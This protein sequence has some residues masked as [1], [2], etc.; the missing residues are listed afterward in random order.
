[1]KEKNRKQMAGLSYMRAIAC[2]GIVGIHTIFSALLL[3]PESLTVNEICGY[4]AMVHNLMWTVPC[5]LMVTGALLLDK[6]KKISY[7]KLFKKYILRILAAMFFWGIWY[8]LVDM[9]LDRSYN[10]RSF[11]SGMY[12]VFAGNSWSHMWYL[13]CLIGLYLFLPFYK[14]I[15]NSCRKRDLSYLLGVSLVFLS[16][17]PLLKELGIPCG[18]YIHTA[19]I[20]PFWLFLGYFITRMSRFSGRFF[21]GLLIFLT[22]FLLTILTFLRWKYGILVPE[23]IFGYS[24]ILVILQAASVFQIV[25]NLKLDGIVGRILREI[26]RKSFCIYFIHMIFIR[27][28]FRA[29]AIN[30]FQ[31]GRGAIWLIAFV[32]FCV[33]YLASALLKNMPV[34]GKFL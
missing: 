34:I 26:D 32:I 13:Y 4:R 11:A 16:L 21:Y 8:S 5:F 2:M 15:I 24:S 9:F 10:I 28:L 1:M 18:F 31:I 33:S 29:A 20:Y 17:L 19:S 25:R 7:E 3:F 23:S 30:P 22:I 6:K 12:K 27:I 14:M